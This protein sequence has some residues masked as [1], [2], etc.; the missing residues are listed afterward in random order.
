MKRKTKKQK[1]NNLAWVEIKY[2]EDL[3]KSITDYCVDNNIRTGF[4]LAIGALQKANFD[5]YN[6][7]EKRFY[8]NIIEEPAEIISCLGNISI[9]DEKPFIHAHLSLSGSKGNVFG[10]HLSEGCIVF[11]AECLIFESQGDLLERKFD[12]LTGLFLWQF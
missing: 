10:G 2:G 6:Q 3:L 7:K 9:K 4:I 11:A 12:E 5:Y 8:E 1:V